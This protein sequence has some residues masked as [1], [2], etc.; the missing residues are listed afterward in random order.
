[1]FGPYENKIMRNTAKPTIKNPIGRDSSLNILTSAKYS[2]KKSMGVHQRFGLTEKMLVQYGDKFYPN[3]KYAVDL[4]EL[5]NGNK[6]KYTTAPKQWF[7]KVTGLY[8]DY[9]EKKAE[10]NRSDLSQEFC[11]VITIRDPF[12]KM[13]IYDEVSSLLKV[14]NFIHR[15]IRLRQFIPIESDQ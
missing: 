5:T 13:F 8:R 10:T 14:N 7:L 1:M 15:N 3:K 12:K 9:I 6:D 2:K 11:L 4:S